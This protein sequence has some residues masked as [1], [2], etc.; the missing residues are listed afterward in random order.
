MK[1][2]CHI[3]LIV[4]LVGSV[5]FIAA[6][7]PSTT[8]ANAQLQQIGAVIGT[9]ESGNWLLPRDQFGG[10]ARKPQLYVWLDAPILMATGIYDD[11]TFRLPTII[12]SFVTA[13]LVYL[14]AR[15]WYGPTTGLLAACLWVTIQH[16]SKMMYV[17]ITDMLLA[18]WIIASIMCA[19]RLLFHRAPRA[20]RKWWAIGLWA[21]MILGAMTKGWGV[22]NLCLVGG[23]LALATAVLPGFGVLRRSEGIG[24]KAAVAARLILRR[25]RRAIGATHFV[26]GM[27]AMVLLLVPVWIG[28]FAQ[29]GDEF[30]QI[31]KYEFWSRITGAG[32]ARPHAGSSPPAI[33]IL[34]YMLPATVF[35]IGALLLTSPRKWFAGLSPVALPLCWILSLVVPFSLTHGF[36][37]DYL[38]PCYGAGAIMGAWAI[39]ELIRRSRAGRIESLVRHVF[40]AGAIG[41]SLIIAVLPAIYLFYE[42][43]P[44][45]VT[46]SIDPPAYMEYGTVGVFAALIPLGV[47]GIGL[48]IWASLTWRIRILVAVTIIAM[49]GVMFVDRHGISRHARTF[50]GE[51]LQEFGI[52][53]RKIMGPD[54]RFAVY[55]AGKLGT[56]LYLGRFGVKIDPP[57]A[58]GKVEDMTFDK[59]FALAQQRAAQA[60]ENLTASGAQWLITCDKGLVELGAA[61]QTDRGRYVLKVKANEFGRSKIAFEPD[62]ELLG[63]VSP[64]TWTAPVVSQRW[65]RVCLIQLDERKLDKFRRDKLYLRAWPIGYRSGK[66]D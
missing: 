52:N 66:Q 28:M 17:A 33:A 29:G 53:S 54:A 63:H 26:W 60:M 25:W 62:P 40:A 37:P 46:K 59:R 39:T 7:G 4:A 13:I 6:H 65:G 9:I 42:H 21:T 41:V 8:Y 43:L 5:V 19:D 3:A 15:R 36:R 38:L 50:D 14:L 57:K 47:I 1:T 2:A 22:L 61:E 49:G 24:A 30:R 32:Q 20:S 27:A 55:R 56:E 64:V 12:A 18:M 48:A 11:F 10:L 34:Y 23:M 16:M 31:A 58:A 51:K 44:E 45:F 35:A